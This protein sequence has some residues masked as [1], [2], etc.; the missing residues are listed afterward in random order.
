M[1][2]LKEEDTAAL[3]ERLWSIFFSEQQQLFEAEEEQY[4]PSLDKKYV[5]RPTIN[6]GL[7]KLQK[8]PATQFDAS[9]EVR[10]ETIDLRCVACGLLTD[11]CLCFLSA[12]VR[13]VRESC[14]TVLSQV[15]FR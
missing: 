14:A 1:Y 2:F 4:G 9:E 7:W 15:H 11:H 5:P 8:E 10:A 3:S 13:N 12:G 6:P